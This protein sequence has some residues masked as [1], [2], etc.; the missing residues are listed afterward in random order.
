LTE[1]EEK[2]IHMKLDPTLA[3]QYLNLIMEIT[4]E[5]RLH[6]TKTGWKVT[7]VDAANVA[8]ID[9]ILPSQEFINYQV[10]VDEEIAVG[11]DTQQI[12]DF[13]GDER[14]HIISDETMPVELQ[15]SL[16]ADK[17]Q[18]QDTTKKHKR[19]T[20]S[21]T[22]GIFSRQILLMN[23]S[24]IRKNPKVPEF[25]IDCKLLVSTLQMRRVCEKAAKVGDY[26]S[27]TASRDTDGAVRLEAVAKD[28]NDFPFKAF[29][30]VYDSEATSIITPRSSMFSLDY[31]I[32]MFKVIQADRVWLSVGQDYPLMIQF[33]LGKEGTAEYMQAPRIESE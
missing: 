29:P 32:P 2:M 18:G 33:K 17:Y 9:V 12:I 28:D 10:D 8:M 25:N 22:Q 4:D 30:K 6:I 16:A 7:A 3:R 21:I 14:D 19:Y 1:S 31:M 27:L 26:I 23:E 11:I 20:L 13:L 24:E 15:F 5:F